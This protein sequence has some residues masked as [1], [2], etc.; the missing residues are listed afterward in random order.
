MKPVKELSAALQARL[1]PPD[2]QVDTK[3]GG[4]DYSK[5]RSI[6]RSQKDQIQGLENEVAHFQSRQHRID[7]GHRLELARLKKE[8]EYHKRLRQAADQRSYE[9]EDQLSR[10]R[11]HQQVAA[12]RESHDD[13]KDS[14]ILQSQLLISK[15]SELTTKVKRLESQVTQ[16]EE[17]KAALENELNQAYFERDEMAAELERALSRQLRHHNPSV[18]LEVEAEGDERDEDSP[19]SGG[20]GTLPADGGSA[21]ERPQVADLAG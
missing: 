16:L 20:D 9:L 17:L 19:E 2:G 12:Q 7:D 15:N 6:I 10:M 21:L 14:L 1:A 13:E 8:V 11:Q 5:L 18:E 3:R 4:S